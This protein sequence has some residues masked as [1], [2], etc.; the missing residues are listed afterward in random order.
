MYLVLAY[1]T[2]SCFTFTILFV[3]PSEFTFTH[4]PGG[5][6]CCRALRHWGTKTAAV[7]DGN[8]LEAAGPGVII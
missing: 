4:L 8:A 3:R 2:S 1:S 6:V 7:A 5:P